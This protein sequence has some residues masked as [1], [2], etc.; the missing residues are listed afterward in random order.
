MQ[1]IQLMNV[2]RKIEKIVIRFM[3]Q[4]ASLTIKLNNKVSVLLHT[5]LSFLIKPYAI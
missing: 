3:R 1:Q 2:S 5:H 4:F